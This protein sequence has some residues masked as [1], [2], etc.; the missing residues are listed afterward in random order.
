MAG[1]RRPPATSAL[2]LFVLVAPF[3][4][5]RRLPGD[6]EG[7]L[8]MCPRCRYIARFLEGENTC[9]MPGH[10]DMARADPQRPG[11]RPCTCGASHWVHFRQEH[12]DGATLRARCPNGAL[13]EV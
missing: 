8:L 4:A 3:L 13:I 12:V 6:E 1:S 2:A 5:S 7:T 11:W 10:G 9:Q